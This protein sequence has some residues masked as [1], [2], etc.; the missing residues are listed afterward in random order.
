MRHECVAAQMQE[1]E[2][3]TAGVEQLP[4]VGLDFLDLDDEFGIE[5]LGG[6]VNDGRAG[7]CVVGVVETRTDTCASLD[8]HRTACSH[9]CG[10]GIRR[11]RHTALA[12]LCFLGQ[13]DDHEFRAQRITYCGKFRARRRVSDPARDK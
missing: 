1:G 2:Q 11:E 12:V 8:S 7:C 9:Q 3:H 6:T 5:C 4:F 10:D 13:S